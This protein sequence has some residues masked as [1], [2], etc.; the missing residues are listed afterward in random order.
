MPN[1][2]RYRVFG[3]TYFFTVNLLERYPTDGFIRHVVV[4]VPWCVKPASTG[5]FISIIA[6]S[7]RLN[8]AWLG[9]CLTGLIQASIDM[10]NGAFI[11]WIGQRSR[12]LILFSGNANNRNGLYWEIKLNE[13]KLQLLACDWIRHSAQYAAEPLAPYAG[14][15]AHDLICK[16]RHELFII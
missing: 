10:W 1:Y 7:T 5:L 14:Y 11:H 15:T 16:L 12:P 4:S 13:R 2:R 8:R 6:I 9:G 3:G